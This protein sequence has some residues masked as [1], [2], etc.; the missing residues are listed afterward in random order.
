MRW[1]TD[2]GMIMVSAGMGVLVTRRAGTL[3]AS[4]GARGFR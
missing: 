3:G 4:T 1:G 2:S